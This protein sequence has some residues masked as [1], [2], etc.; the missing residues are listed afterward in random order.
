VR[1]LFTEASAPSIPTLQN[2]ASFTYTASRTR[3]I[4]ALIEYIDGSQS[5]IFAKTA[6]CVSGGSICSPAILLRSGL[7]K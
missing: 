7:I 2:L 1:L 3:C 5:V 4:G 6:V